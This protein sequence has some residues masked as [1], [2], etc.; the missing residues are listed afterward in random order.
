VE[1]VLSAI[2]TQISIKKCK[3]VKAVMI[4]IDANSF[5]V[6]AGSSFKS[7]VKTLA[8]IFGER[9]TRKIPFL[10]VVNKCENLTPDAVQISV[11][12][13]I[14][15]GRRSLRTDPSSSEI[16]GMLKILSLMKIQNIRVANIFEQSRLNCDEIEKA[17]E[18]ISAIP[19]SIEDFQFDISD[20]F[21][22]KFDSIIRS[23]IEEKMKLINDEK[24]LESKINELRDKIRRD[25]ERHQFAQKKRVLSDADLMNDSFQDVITEMEQT[26]EKLIEKRSMC[27]KKIITQLDLQ[28]K[29]DE[30]SK[31]ETLVAYFRDS[32]EET[33]G[34]FGLLGSTKKEFR[35]EGIPFVDVIE[36]PAD[37]FRRGIFE[38]EN[39]HY[40]SIYESGL[41]KDGMASICIRIKKN[42]H[43]DTKSEISIIEDELRT[44]A[45]EIRA[46]LEEVKDDEE[47]IKFL[48]DFIKKGIKDRREMLRKEESEYADSIRQSRRD[49]QYS[50]SRARNKKL[51]EIRSMT[52]KNEYGEIIYDLSKVLAFEPRSYGLIDKFIKSY[53]HALQATRERRTRPSTGGVSQTMTTLPQTQVLNPSVGAPS[54]A[55][56]SQTMTTL[57]QTQVLN[58]SV[59]APSQA[60]DSQTMATLPQTQVV[61]VDDE[62]ETSERKRSR[63]E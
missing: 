26:K 40:S 33:R 45:E 20:G 46:L 44:K 8:K 29:K 24:E 30:L 16:I 47:R 28:K 15:A 2:S 25:E 32:V 51:D 13:A 18:K 3:K 34:M 41:G 21:R 49:I 58:P 36:E 17:L 59:G 37:R 14:Q 56:D 60:A 5:N 54:Q 10:F 11:R 63:E 38:P 19:I 43:P 62:N 27:D 23:V 50:L 1:K 42:D 53:D 55:A 22:I 57:P 9:L 31:N 7:L 4:V 12:D 6:S 52:S 39:G 61:D 48:E 35:Y